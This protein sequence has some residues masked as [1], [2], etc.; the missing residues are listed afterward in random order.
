MARPLWSGTIQISLVGFAV[1]IYPATNT[2][3]PISFHEVDRNTLGRVHH[4]RVSAGSAPAPESGETV[5]GEEAERAED[6]SAKHKTSLHIAPRASEHEAALETA[7]DASQH[8]VEKGDIVKGYE[9]E[10]G[11]YAIVEPAEL[12]NLRLAGKKTIEISQFAKAT[13]IN[14]ALYDKPYFVVPKAGPQ[15]KAFAVVRQSM[16]DTGM[17]GAG[18][19]VFSGR[20]HLIALAPPHDPEQPGMMLYTLRFA[21]ELRD[22]RDYFKDVES[23]EADPAQLGLAKQLIDAYTQPFEI[24]KFRDHYEDALRELVEAKIKHVPAPTPAPEKKPAKVIDLM[25]ALRRSLAQRSP[26]Q[27]ENAQ[28]PGAQNAIDGKPPKKPSRPST[29]KT[30]AA[31]TGRSR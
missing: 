15:A 28:Q 21:T 18:E 30:K 19:I 14:P 17:V 13:E 29:A 7:E 3:R 25:E 4:Q 10:K 2:T 20:Q 1:E 5:V 9:Y 27:A 24:S 22:P 11:K 12:K 6:T 31:G 16:I 26:S 8:A 23:M